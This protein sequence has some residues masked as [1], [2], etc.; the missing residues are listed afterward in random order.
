MS[1]G[2][3][4]HHFIFAFSEIAKKKFGCKCQ[5]FELGG[6]VSVSIKEKCDFL[7][8]KQVLRINN[9]W[10]GYHVQGLKFSVATTDF[11]Q[12]DC[13]FPNINILNGVG[14]KQAI[15]ASILHQTLHSCH[16]ALGC[17]SDTERWSSYSCCVC[18]GDALLCSQIESLFSAGII[19]L[20]PHL[21]YL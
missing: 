10:P 13:Q 9:D 6:F 15:T 2:L 18:Y 16:T 8:W 21:C 14:N 20:I 5:K 11:R 12:L 7:L 1:S 17:T 3:S 4:I 19:I